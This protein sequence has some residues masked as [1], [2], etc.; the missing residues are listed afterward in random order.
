[1]GIRK[2]ESVPEK[3]A[4]K[5]GRIREAGEEIGNNQLPKGVVY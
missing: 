3:K 1:M 2:K 5:E 4:C